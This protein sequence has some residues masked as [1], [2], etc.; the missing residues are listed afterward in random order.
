MVFCLVHEW[1][2]FM[3][4]CP[5]KLQVNL[6]CTD[7]YQRQT[8]LPYYHVFPHLANILCVYYFTKQTVFTKCFI[9][10]PTHPHIQTTHCLRALATIHNNAGQAMKGGS[11]YGPLKETGNGPDINR[12]FPGEAN[13]NRKWS[14]PGLDK[15]RRSSPWQ[16]GMWWSWTMGLAGVCG[17]I[18]S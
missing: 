15:G 5:F 2:M 7:R 10:G 12:K 3:S 8:S 17:T 1:N 6:I 18:N 13:S 9:A 16:W 4:A 11:W 14:G